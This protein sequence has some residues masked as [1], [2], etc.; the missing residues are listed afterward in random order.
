MTYK[1][2]FLTIFFAFVIIV[3]IL[4]YF[5]LSTLHQTNVGNVSYDNFKSKANERIE[6]IDEFFQPYINSI[7]ALQK[8]K[9]LQEYLSGNMLIKEIIQNDFLFVKHSLACSTKVRYIDMNGNENIRIEGTPIALF[10]EKAVSKIVANNELQKKSNRDYVKQFMKLEDNQVGFSNID[11]NKEHGKI[12]IPKQPTL[13]LGIAALDLNGNKKGIIVINICLRSFFELLNNTTLYNVH[14]ID[15]NGKF[16]S[17]HDNRY[18]LMGDNEKYSLYDEYPNEVDK[19]LKNDIYQTDLLFSQSLKLF[20]NEQKIKILLE[21]KY[22]EAILKSYYVQDI[23]IIVAILILFVSFFFVI[24]YSKL[25]DLLKEQLK[26]KEEIENKNIFIESLLKSVP[27]PLFYKD[28]NGAYFNINDAFTT[29]FGFEKEEL[30]GKTVFDVAPYDLAKEYHAH[31]EE[32]Y[33]SNSSQSQIYESE[34]FNKISGKLHKVVFHKSLFFDAKGKAQGIIGAAVD[35]T[36]LKNVQS[37]LVELNDNLEHQVIEQVA[38]NTKQEIQ[39]F[40]SNK[41]AAMGSMIGH[42]IHQWKQPLNLISIE[43]SM[44]KFQADIDKSLDPKQISQ[45]MNVIMDEVRR[46]TDITDTFRNF[47]KEKKERKTVYMQGVIEK[48]LTIC[49]TLKKNNSIHLI[50]NIQK[51]PI[52]V[53]IVPNELI[54]VVINIVN[55]ALDVFNEKEIEE[56]KIFI[57]LYEKDDKA[58]LSIED[59]GGGIPEDVLPHVFEEYFTTKDDDKGTGLGL[60]MCEKIVTQSLNGK[61]SVINT[62]QGAKFIME[63]PIN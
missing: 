63:F 53:N 36:E 31:D 30:I 37:Q 7:K 56:P 57:D 11:L 15:K 28:I 50:E 52:S 4:L 18:G 32:L 43:A 48:A 29:I 24:Y 2:K 49:S 61:I 44:V 42:I 25:P 41:L 40:E 45:T 27:I 3:G 54:E 59:N 16:L 23:F 6:F 5:L 17:H 35:I 13:R 34:V 21:Y 60:Y 14:L 10:N 38:K 12:S 46:L 51:E 1:N 19:I 55:N 8:D 26:D 20:D 33:Q 62:N 9:N 47:L 58:F 39:L 22:G